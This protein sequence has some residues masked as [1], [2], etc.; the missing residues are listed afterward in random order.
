MMFAVVGGGGSASA[1]TVDELETA[2]WTKVTASTITGTNDNYYML[3]DAK[4]AGYVMS[5]DATHY[6]PCYKTIN[7]PV[8]NPS[9]V[10][11][12]EGSENTFALKSY[13]TG[14]YFLEASGWNTSMTGST[15]STTFTF[16]LA[17]GK[18]SLQANGRTDYVGHWNDGEDGVASD[19]ESIAANKAANHTDNFLLY[20]ISK[21]TYDADLIAARES[22]ATGA[23]DSSPFEATAWIQNADWSGDWGGWAR[24][25][26]WGNQQWGEKTLESWNANNVVVKQELRGVPNGKYKVQADVISGNDN[27]KVA[28]VFGTGSAKVSSAPVSAV[29]SAGDYATMSAEVA[30]NTLTADN[31]VVT[32]NTL[33]IGIDQASGWIVA[34]NF[35]LYY[36]GEDLSIYVDAYNE[37]VTAAEAVDLDAPMLATAKSALQTAISNYGTGVDT[38]DKDALLTA[39]S[40][41][42]NATTNAT[43]SI[44]AYAPMAPVIAKI[45]AALEAATSAT[46]STDAYDAI[47]TA[48]NNGT[49]AN[50]DIPAQIIAAYEAVIP[51]IKSQT[52]ASGNF[53]LAVQNQSFEYG[54]MT[55]WTATSSSDTGVRSTSNEQYAATGS[56]GNYLFNTWWQGV[57]ITQSVSDLPNGQYTLTASVASDGATIYLIANGEHNN[58]TE[59]GGKYPGKDTFQDASITFL[60]KDGTATIGAVG[61]AN[62][63]AG[64]HKDYVEAGYWWYKADNFRLVKNR[65]LTPEEE[66]VVPTAIALYNGENEVT[67]PIALDPTTSTVTLTPSYTPANATEGVTWSSSDET[68]ASVADGVVTAVSSGT[69]TITATSTLDA[70]VSATATVNVSFPETEVASYV[71]DGATRTVRNWGVNLIKNGTFEYPNPFYSWKSG[72]NGNCDANNFNIVT[73]GDNKYIQ[74]KASQGAGDSHSIST[75][76]AIE[77]GKT[78]VFGYKAKASAAISD[79]SKFIVV[80]MTNTIGTETAKV[81]NDDTPVTT[82]WTDVEYEFTNTDGYAYVQFRARWLANN[83]SF[84]DFYLCEVLSDPT[85]EGNVDYAKAAIPTAN[86]GTGAFQYSQDAINAAD[87]LVQGTATVAEVETAYAAVTTLNAPE[88][89]QAYNL[90]FN[91]KGHSANGNALT[92]IPNSAQAQGLYGLKY[93]APANV[94]LAQAFYFVHTT[95]NKY[96]VFAV[97]TDGNDRYITTQAEGYG[98]TWYDGIRTIDDASK[99]MEVEIRPNGEGLY[100]LWNTGANKPLGH[101]GNDNNDLFT[102]NTANFQFVATSKPSIT[103]NTTAAGWGTTILPFGGVEIPAGV[104]AYSCAAVE[105]NG[106]TLTLVEVSALEANKPY[107]IEGAW[108]ETLTGDAQ[109]TALTYTVGLLTG[110]YAA[111]LAPVDS[112]VLQKN[113][114]KVAFYQVETGEQPT[115]GANRAYLTYEAPAGDAK[116]RAFFFEGDDATAIATISALTSGEVEAIYT[117]GGARVNS[118]QKGINIVKMQNGETKK[119]IVK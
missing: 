76:W 54:D 94:N 87:A 60:V 82:S 90:V 11:I 7:D 24:S 68:V 53:T 112:Y 92:L 65:D 59:T 50:A 27:N 3:V 18:Y 42:G 13:S 77:S 17:E 56:D 47:K 84:D 109:G 117:I 106:T 58:G 51:V 33:T 81:S 61:G 41:L 79:K 111:T 5:C 62:G 119:V 40:A 14:A 101:N 4:A 22:A 49:I 78:Y 91:C 100:L 45:D 69:A 63:T 64:E 118:L 25:G 96:K 28:Y 55:G 74:A 19:G 107:I 98:T 30:G 85:T 29:A 108:N 32:N 16:T 2:G 52:A 93:L 103:I 1:Y 80:S 67:E 37:A 88:V 8:A 102:N 35:K 48:Y 116:A 38:S 39:T 43:T 20:S 95:G 86:I 15:G 23:S 72:A 97:D 115:V 71:N 75:G 9:F 31:I 83:L 34:D 10:W 36:Y 21:A 6:R 26:S 104:K 89:T 12:L 99:A 66:A 110:V 46:A 113:G 105:S 114:D 73:D 57:P 70:T 44:A